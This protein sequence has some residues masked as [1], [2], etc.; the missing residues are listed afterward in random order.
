MSLI[1]EFSCLDQSYSL[2]EKK[3]LLRVKVDG[4][5]LFQE[6]SRSH[7]ESPLWRAV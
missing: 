7:P 3:R 1:L 4:A 6:G 5:T 2:I